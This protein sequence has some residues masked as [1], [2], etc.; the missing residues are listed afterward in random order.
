MQNFP[1]VF[2][3]HQKFF[4]SSNG[5]ILNRWTPGVRAPSDGEIS[6]AMRVLRTAPRST[7]PLADATSIRRAFLNRSSI[8][9]VGAVI[10]ACHRLGIEMRI[11]AR[12][13]VCVAIMPSW[14]REQREKDRTLGRYQNHRLARDRT[15]APN[16]ETES[17]QYSQFE[18]RDPC[19]FFPVD[20]GLF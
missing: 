7:Y 10:V 2:L 4:V 8:S 9:N 19:P 14:V 16:V 5:L 15:S 1:I 11:D 12:N 18:E 17:D 3:N 13:G 6:A 20:Y